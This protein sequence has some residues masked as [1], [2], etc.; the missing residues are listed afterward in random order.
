MALNPVILVEIVEDTT[1]QSFKTLQFYK[2]KTKRWLNITQYLPTWDN[3][4]IRSGHYH[5]NY[6]GYRDNYNIKS[7]MHALQNEY[8]SFS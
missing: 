2:S 4:W 7:I 8:T 3:Q 1:N 5:D 6:I